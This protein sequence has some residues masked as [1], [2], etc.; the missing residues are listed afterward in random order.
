MPKILSAGIPEAERHPY[1]ETDA[2][3]CDDDACGC[4]FQL[5]PGDRWERVKAEVRPDAPESARELADRIDLVRAECPLCGGR[6]R[7]HVENGDG[8]P[9]AAAPVRSLDST[10]PGDPLPRHTEAPP[11][12]RVARHERG[13]TVPFKTTPRVPDPDFVPYEDRLGPERR[14]EIARAAH[15]EGVEIKE[16]RG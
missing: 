14:A 3:T 6:A 16:R 4:T 13:A 7:A 10:G 1:L 5:E 12:A 15:V 9:W 2:L 8:I 11:G